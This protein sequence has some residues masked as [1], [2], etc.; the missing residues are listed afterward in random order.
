MEIIF[1]PHARYRMRIRRIRDE[2]IRFVLDNGQFV[3]YSEDGVGESWRA[4]ILG[5]TIEVIVE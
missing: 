3:G 5:R 2:H 4:R 1:T